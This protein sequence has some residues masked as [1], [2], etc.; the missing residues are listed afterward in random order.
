MPLFADAAI[1]LSVTMLQYSLRH[2]CHATLDIT[3]LPCRFYAAAEF[4][5]YCDA[6]ISPL[7]YLRC[8]TLRARLF[9]IALMPCM[10]PDDRHATPCR[11]RLRDTPCHFAIRLRCHIRAV[12][13]RSYAFAALPLLMPRCYALVEA[14]CFRCCY[15][16]CFTPRTRAYAAMLLSEVYATRRYSVIF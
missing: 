14:L 12:T 13:L 9:A 16:A 10:L 2:C 4:A 15:I 6:I 11:A 3:L 5:D 1:C 8:A 7:L